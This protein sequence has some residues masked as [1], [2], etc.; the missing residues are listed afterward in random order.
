MPEAVEKKHKLRTQGDGRNESGSWG[1]SGCNPHKVGCKQRWYPD[2][3]IS[4]NAYLDKKGRYYLGNNRRRIGSGFGR[5]RAEKWVGKVHAH[6]ARQIAKGHDL[7]KAM[8][9][10]KIMRAAKKHIKTK[11]PKGVREANKKLLSEKTKE[12]LQAS[13]AGINAKVTSHG[14]WTEKTTVKIL[15]KSANELIPQKAVKRVEAADAKKK[16]DGIK[17]LQKCSK[18]HAPQVEGFKVA[19]CGDCYFKYAAPFGRK[20]VGLLKCATYCRK[21]NCKR[22]SYGVKNVKGKAGLGCRV[23]KGKDKCPIA[24][25]R[26]CRSK[27]PIHKVKRWGA[28]K[29]CC[30]TQA[31]CGKINYWGG[32]IYEPSVKVKNAKKTSKKAAKKSK[33]G[34]KK[35]RTCTPA[36]VKGKEFYT[37]EARGRHCYHIIAGKVL[38]QDYRSKRASKCNK[39]GFRKTVTIGR[40]QGISKYYPN[41][42]STGCPGRRKRSAS[43]TIKRVPGIRKE[44][45]SVSEPRTCHYSITISTPHRTKRV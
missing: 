35:T 39:A 2:G 45:A 12:T 11:L 10:K 32:H 16:A 42:D 29:V 5:R 20:P 33:K 9:G 26:Y 4:N 24:A 18:P 40:G 17:A 13:G 25:E 27:Y 8:T 34:K 15:G 3:A 1:A 30:S 31:K 43:L 37:W 28:T 7:L 14:Q 36:E 41:G 21:H 38:E 22:F 23:S 44:T 6:M 19:G